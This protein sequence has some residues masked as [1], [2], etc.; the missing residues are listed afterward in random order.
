MALRVFRNE[1]LR[2]LEIEFKSP[3]AGDAGYDLFATDNDAVPAWSTRAC[4]RRACIS[5][6]QRDW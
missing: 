5:R 3:R 4:G 2:S 1:K 6:S